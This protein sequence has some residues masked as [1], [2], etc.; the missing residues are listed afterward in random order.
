MTDNKLDQ[1]VTVS[2]RF[3]K[4]DDDLG[5]ILRDGVEVQ[6]AFGHGRHCFIIVTKLSCSAHSTTL[7]RS[8]AA[9]S[10]RF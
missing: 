6:I 4:I 7:Q 5:K 2:R 8:H 9:K 1:P 3:Q 10:M